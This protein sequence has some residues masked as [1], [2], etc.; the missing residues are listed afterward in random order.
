MHSKIF[1]TVFALATAVIAAPTPKAEPTDIV[2]G[3]LGS[4]FGNGNGNG[5]GNNIGSGDGAN[6]NGNGNGN[7][8][9]NGK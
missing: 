2:T 7:G 5:N 6:G 9:K 8:N 1:I 3:L 4:P